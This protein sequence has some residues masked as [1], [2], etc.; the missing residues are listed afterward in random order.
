MLPAAAGRFEADFRGGVPLP[1]WT[2]F[3]EPGK[4][5]P[6]TDEGKAILLPVWKG[7]EVRE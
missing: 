2:K 1:G 6:A 4:L 5:A 7:L 3:L